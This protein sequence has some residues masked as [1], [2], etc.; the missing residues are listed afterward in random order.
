LDPPGQARLGR[1]RFQGM[2]NMKIKRKICL[3]LRSVQN[4][5]ETG[6]AEF[7]SATPEK[8]YTPRKSTLKKVYPP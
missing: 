1:G 5:S 4:L 2:E 3:S 7:T 8:K 6:V